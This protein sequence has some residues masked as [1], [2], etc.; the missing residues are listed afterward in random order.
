MTAWIF[1]SNPDRYDLPGA[2]RESSVETWLANQHRSEIKAGDTAYLWET[3]KQSGILAVA[4]V[5]SE[6]A[7]MPQSTGDTKFALGDFSGDRWRVRLQVDKVLTPRALKTDLIKDPILV[8]L[9]NIRF[10]QATNFRLS[11]EEAAALAN[12]VAAAGA[13]TEDEEGEPPALTEE[14]FGVLARHRTAIPWDEIS[15]EDRGLISQLRAKLGAGGPRIRA[16]AAA[17]ACR[18]SV[19]PMGLRERQ[20]PSLRDRDNE[21]PRGRGDDSPVGGRERLHDA[22]TD[23]GDGRPNRGWPFFPPRAAARSPKAA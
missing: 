14:D 19:P 12:I 6:P 11:S 3:G 16:A 10:A 8:N 17:E 23:W 18:R 15:P 22:G 1:Q 20:A 21:P 9:P 2:L 5:L 4:T 13:D 7:M